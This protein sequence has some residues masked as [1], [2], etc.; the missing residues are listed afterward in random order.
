VQKL[1][2]TQKMVSS[3]EKL[4]EVERQKRD[5][6][7]DFGVAKNNKYFGATHCAC[8]ANESPFQN[9]GETD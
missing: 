2:R 5:A 4:D 3:D 9:G 6:D 1:D 8:N 7:Q